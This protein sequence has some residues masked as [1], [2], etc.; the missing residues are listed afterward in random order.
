M[1]SFLPSMYLLYSHLAIDH[2][3]HTC[4]AASKRDHHIGDWR[5]V[6]NAEECKQQ[7]GFSE[8]EAR[9]KLGLPPKS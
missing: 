9:R 8:E 2:N 1:K 3:E 7:G 6:A 4:G 5:V